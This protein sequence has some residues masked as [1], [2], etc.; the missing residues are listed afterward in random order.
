[1][2]KENKAKNIGLLRGHSFLILFPLMS[3]SYWCTQLFLPF[4]LLLENGFLKGQ[5]SLLVL[6][7]A[8]G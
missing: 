4:T 3:I 5:Y 8:A 6:I 2:D 1:M 7:T